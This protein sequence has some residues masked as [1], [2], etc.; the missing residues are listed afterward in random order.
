VTCAA[1]ERE[2]PELLA[3]M[4]SRRRRIARGSGKTEVDVSGLLTAYTGMRARMGQMS[5]MMNISRA[6]G[7]TQAHTAWWDLCTKHHTDYLFA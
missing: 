4:P 7:E 5:K 3:K 6:G 1:Q 2:Q